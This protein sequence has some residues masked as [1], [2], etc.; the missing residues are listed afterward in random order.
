M[1]ALY[2]SFSALLLATAL[3]P[4][5]AAK[6][7]YLGLLDEP[8]ARKIHRAAVPRVGGI[9]IAVGTLLSILLWFPVR[10]EITG[11]I[12]GGI[13]IVAFGIADDR[14]D[15]DYRI[16]F[17]GQI[18][19]AIAFMLI[20][21]IQLTRVPFEYGHVWP[22]WLGSLLT[23]L[24]LVGVTNAVNLSDGMDGLAAG[25]SLLAAA[26]IG[27][28]AYTGG[29]GTIA[30]VALSLISATLGFLRYNTHPAQV[31]MGDAGSQFLGYSIAALS[32][33]LVEESNTAI[34][35]L[36]PVLLLGLPILD[37]LYVM[38]RRVFSG[39][40]PFSPDRL[41]LHYRLLDAGMTQ[42]TAV[43]IIYAM[44]ASLILI[45]WLLQ[46]A[47]DLTLLGAYLAFCTALLLGVKVLHLGKP[48]TSTGNIAQ[49][50]ERISVAPWYP[51][52]IAAARTIG[53]AVV[54]GGVSIML[55]IAAVLSNGTSLDIAW[56]SLALL[57]LLITTLRW[58]WMP[59]LYA[60]RLAAYGT[61]AMIV[62]LV[63]DQGP[64]LIFGLSLFHVSIL[65]IALGIGLWLKFG[66]DNEF[67]VNALDLLIALVVAIVPQIS[68]VKDNGMG[69]L[70][71]ETAVLLYACEL[72]LN[73]RKRGRD[74][75]RIA[76]LAAL[77]VLAG[78]GLQAT[79]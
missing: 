52:A 34:S 28:L 45:A 15:L 38:V 55:P 25:T 22:A 24:A 47:H 51:R 20:G 19:A 42:Q 41:H 6:A 68:V 44:Q 21:D 72:I 56:F 69:S 13:V 66:N 29:D 32:I 76:T 60:D 57:L 14:F 7:A 73:R 9:A 53:R 50:G 12:A 79:G 61:S 49:H 10:T 64:P 70:I 36:V 78:S 67:R 1:S 48:Q 31:F 59:I 74:V 18:G 8:S 39:R 37:T 17:V 27:Y 5:L 62:Y 71:I 43:T 3:V 4:M 40:S 63:S 46:F 35:P 77:A 16:K 65:L 11:Y 33:I 75:F 54:L 23:I 26:A 30:L 58:R 2:G